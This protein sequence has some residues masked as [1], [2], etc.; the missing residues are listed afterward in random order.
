[1]L[2]EVI[3][4]TFGGLVV[5][6][7][8]RYNTRKSQGASIEGVITS[9]SIHYTKLYEV[10][11]QKPAVSYDDFMKM[12][13]RIGTILEAEKVAKT[14]KLL[15]LKVDTGVDQRTVVSGIAEYFE[16][17]KIIGK[18]VTLLLNLEPRVIT[19][20]SIHYTKL[21]EWSVPDRPVLHIPTPIRWANDNRVREVDPKQPNQRSES[22]NATG[23]KHWPVSR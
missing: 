12:D 20:Y 13:I 8:C 15:K 19:S 11:I 21:Y 16:P 10:A 9:Y 18:Q 14:K 2:Y 1:M 4:N 7:Q 22:W 17:D 6:E 23:K 3:T 5:F